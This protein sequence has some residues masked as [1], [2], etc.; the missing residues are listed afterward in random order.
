MSDEEDCRELLEAWEHGDD[1]RY[2]PVRFSKSEASADSIADKEQLGL[3]ARHI[4]SELRGMAGQLRAGSIA[5]D[6][7]YR[8]G[9]EHACLNCPYLAACSFVDGQNGEKSRVLFRLSA[10]EVWKKMKEAE[11][12]V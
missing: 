12:H 6:P 10:A 2:I 9:Q 1:K 7:Y 11:D 8:S 3:L 5:A 4:K